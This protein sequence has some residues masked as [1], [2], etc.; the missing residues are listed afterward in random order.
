MAFRDDTNYV[1]FPVYMCVSRAH[2][3][4]REGKEYVHVS[5]WGTCINEGVRS[6]VVLIGGLLTCE[7]S[8]FQ[9]VQCTPTNDHLGRCTPA[10][11]TQCLISIFL[12]SIRVHLSLGSC[13][14]NSLY[15]N[16]I[17]HLWHLWDIQLTFYWKCFSE[18]KKHQEIGQMTR[19]PNGTSI[20]KIGW[21]IKA[22]VKSNRL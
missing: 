10:P 17:L 7:L 5:V 19:N 4:D 6:R 3:N 2:D 8:W 1:Y 18:S 21:K 11:P 14:V 9:G 20:F 15:S 16:R 12:K 13:Y 22:Q